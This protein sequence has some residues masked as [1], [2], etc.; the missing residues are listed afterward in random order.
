MKMMKT[1]MEFVAFDAQDIIT[2]SGPTGFSTVSYITGTTTFPGISGYDGDPNKIVLIS[3]GV[4]FNEQYMIAFNNASEYMSGKYQGVTQ[5]GEVS[6]I[7]SIPG[8][9]NAELDPIDINTFENYGA[10]IEWLSK[11]SNGLLGQ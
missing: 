1:E 5:T 6:D 2:A 3:T 9:E 8:Y 7:N 11:A 10:V 4:T